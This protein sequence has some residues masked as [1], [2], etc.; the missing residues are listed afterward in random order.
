MNI[1]SPSEWIEFREIRNIIA[2]EYTIN[3]ENELIENINKIFKSID[4]LISI[5]KNLEK[6]FLELKGKFNEAK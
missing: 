6:E 5:S 1:L 2:H 4:K 3:D